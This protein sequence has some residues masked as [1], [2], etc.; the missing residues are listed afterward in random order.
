[1]P[2]HDFLDTNILVYAYDISDPAK[3]RVAQDLVRKAVAGGFVI[4]TQVL[5]EFAAT[6]LHKLSPAPSSQDVIALLD[7]LAPI[8]FILPDH[9]IVRRA[10]EAK[11]AYGLH[12]YDGMIVAAAERAGSER[13][14]S[15]DLNP[16]QKYFGV[17]VADPFQASS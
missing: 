13:I 15:E 7:A 9:E 8:H 4:S 17:L 3:Q 6:L 2:G 14:W 1:M 5:A 12:F 11:S 16:G 10:V